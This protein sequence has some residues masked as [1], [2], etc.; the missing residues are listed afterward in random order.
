MP[1]GALHPHPHERFLDCVVRVPSVTQDLSS[2]SERLGPVLLNQC[3]ELFFIGGGGVASFRLLQWAVGSRRV[4]LALERF[5]PPLGPQT[6]SG[7]MVFCQPAEPCKHL[8][9]RSNTA[10]SVARPALQ[11]AP[12]NSHRKPCYRLDRSPH[13]AWRMRGHRVARRRSRKGHCLLFRCGL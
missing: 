5:A 13:R 1:I 4:G 9:A 3:R 11:V 10:P 12:W 6:I 7:S 2:V 8:R